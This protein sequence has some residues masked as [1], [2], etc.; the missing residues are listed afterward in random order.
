MRCHPFSGASNAIAGR[1]ERSAQRDVRLLPPRLYPTNISWRRETEIARPGQVSEH[2]SCDEI[3]GFD[4][5][6]NLRSRKGKIVF[7]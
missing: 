3:G 1:V 6:D 2:G 7:D 4:E 5:G